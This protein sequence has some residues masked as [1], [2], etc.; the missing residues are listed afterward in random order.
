MRFKTMTDVN[1]PLQ[2]AGPEGSELVLEA[3][4]CLKRWI[5]RK[6]YKGPKKKPEP[7][8]ED[9]FS[10]LMDGLRR[11]A[12]LY[13]P[14][15]DTGRLQD[16]RRAEL[17][18]PSPCGLPRIFPDQFRKREWCQAAHKADDAL[19]ELKILLVAQLAEAAPKKE[20]PEK[21]V[22]ER[23]ALASRVGVIE[24]RLAELASYLQLALAYLTSDPQ[25]S[26]TKARIVLEKVLIAL[27]RVAMKKEPARP[28]IGDM[29][30]DKDFVRSIPRRIHTRMNAIRDM[31]NLG[32]H[33]EAVEPT[34]AVRVMRDLLEVLEW[35][36]VK[37]DPNSL[38]SVNQ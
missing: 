19:N 20:V 13:A 27:Y 17:N 4:E 12:T 24:A 35:Y 1:E 7:K 31:A 10:R 5:Y 38:V 15:I 18:L 21:E 11:W 8:T 23:H 34:D 26:L 32:P 2:S 6:E 33:G 29:L 30:A 3:I 36:V 22:Q 37:Y 16:Y 25:S 28:M 14:H 9:E